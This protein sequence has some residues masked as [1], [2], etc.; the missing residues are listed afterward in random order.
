MTLTPSVTWGV[1]LLLFV[2]VLTLLWIMHDT[3]E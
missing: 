2:G 1:I 3:G